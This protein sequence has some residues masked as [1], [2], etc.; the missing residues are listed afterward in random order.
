LVCVSTY[1]QEGR[2]RAARVGGKEH[3]K[4]TDVMDISELY[5]SSTPGGIYNH[6]NLLRLKKLLYVELSRSSNG[7]F[8]PLLDPGGGSTS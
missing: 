4:G 6:A 2:Q 8:K 1:Q 7:Y 3:A 5:S